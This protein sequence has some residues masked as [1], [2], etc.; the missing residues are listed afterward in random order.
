MT[1]FPEKMKAALSPDMLA[2]DL[3]GYLVR[4]D[5]PFRKAHDISGR[6]VALAEREGKP[7]DQ[8][9]KQQ[10]Q[11]VDKR[12]G[13][14]VLDCSNYEKGVEYRNEGGTSKA[15]VKK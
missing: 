8:L 3:A 6:V 1:I 12:F 15:G 10:V 13:G 2:T 11:E 14:D 7:M 9:S 5:V 4:K